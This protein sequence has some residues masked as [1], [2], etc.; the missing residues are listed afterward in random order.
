[1]NQSDTVSIPA[2]AHGQFILMCVIASADHP[3]YTQPQ[4]PPSRNLTDTVC[5]QSVSTCM[6]L[7]VMNCCSMK[8]KRRVFVTRSGGF[9]RNMAV[10]G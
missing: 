3:H 8:E 4:C 2:V 1:M 6:K 5:K 9:N 10:P 7:C